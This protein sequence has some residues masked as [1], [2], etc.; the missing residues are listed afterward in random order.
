MTVVTTC[1]FSK[2]ITEREKFVTVIWLV[3]LQDHMY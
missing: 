2:K 3:T 1:R